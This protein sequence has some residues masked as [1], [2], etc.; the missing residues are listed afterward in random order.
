MPNLPGASPVGRGRE[1]RSYIAQTFSKS[2]VESG[3]VKESGQRVVTNGRG[4]SEAIEQSGGEQVGMTW[5]ARPVRGEGGRARTR[6]WTDERY[7]GRCARMRPSLGTARSEPG[8]GLAWAPC[9]RGLNQERE[10]LRLG[11]ERPGPS[12]GAAT[13]RCKH[14]LVCGWSDLDSL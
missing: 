3:D 12:S 2:G 13:T 10:W 1:G 4:H 9:G 8:A 6:A 11:V 5:G 7:K 14:D